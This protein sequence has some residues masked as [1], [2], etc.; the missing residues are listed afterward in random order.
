MSPRS[1][2]FRYQRESTDRRRRRRPDG[3]MTRSRGH[4]AVRT[5]PRCGDEGRNPVYVPMAADSRL[6]PD[7]TFC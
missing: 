6:A 2:A 5:G 4:R 7:P 3:A 1:P